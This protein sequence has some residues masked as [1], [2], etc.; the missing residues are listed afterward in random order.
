MTKVDVRWAHPSD[1]D[2]MA[3]IAESSGFVIPGVEIDW[4]KLGHSWIAAEIDGEIVGA[5]Q[6]LIGYP[7]GRVDYLLLDQSLPKVTKAIVV[8]TMIRV[9]SQMMKA[10]GVEVVCTYVNE[11]KDPSHYGML[12]EEGWIPQFK[13]MALLGITKEL[14]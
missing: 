6:I 9:M 8:V 1:A 3:R 7:V 4:S 5:C 2:S 12:L 13:A 14:R 11:E 10:A